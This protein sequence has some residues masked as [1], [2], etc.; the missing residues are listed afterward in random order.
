MLSS[1]IQATLIGRYAESD[2]GKSKL[3]GEKFFFDYS[4]ENNSI[5]LVYRF[6]KIA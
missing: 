2:Y 6:V 1:S 3:E 4:K 5:V